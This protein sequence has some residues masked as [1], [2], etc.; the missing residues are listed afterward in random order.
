MHVSSRNGRKRRNGK[1]ARKVENKVKRRR[2]RNER[3]NSRERQK[4]HVS[5]LRRRPLPLQNR[6]LHPKRERR[7][8]RRS[9][10]PRNLL[11][12]GRSLP[13]EDSMR[14]KGR[15]NQWNLNGRWRAMWPQGLIMHSI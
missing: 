12:Q 2:K 5:W 14:R 4:T 7:K 3:P 11:V 10:K 9:P 6:N 15:R 8:A 13:V 1:K